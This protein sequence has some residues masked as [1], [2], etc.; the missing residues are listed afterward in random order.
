MR[1]GE[2]LF[3]TIAGQIGGAVGP[4]FKVAT[5][6]CPSACPCACDWDPDPVCDIFDFLAFQNGFVAGD[7]CACDY[8]PDP[9]CNI[10][11]F[12]AFQSEFVMG[13]P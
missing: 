5:Q 7:P 4:N 6:G 2:L 12:L 1:Q 11:D 3:S 13:C 9:A 8:D 10:F